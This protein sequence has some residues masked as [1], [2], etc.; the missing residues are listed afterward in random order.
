MR[1]RG[2]VTSIERRKRKVVYTDFEDEIGIGRTLGLAGFDGGPDYERFLRKARVYVFDRMDTLSLRKVYNNFPLTDA[3]IDDL[4]RIIHDAS[5]GTSEDEER[6]A[7]EAGGSGVFIRSLIGLDRNAAKEPF[8]GFL[9]GKRNSS[10]RHGSTSFKGWAAHPCTRSQPTGG[11]GTHSED[12]TLRV[13]CPHRPD[14]GLPS[15][16]R[17]RRERRHLIRHGRKAADQRSPRV[18]RHQPDSAARPASIS[19]SPEAGTLTG[20]T[21]RARMSASPKLMTITDD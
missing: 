20:G 4:R 9:D 8:A 6:A 12:G 5:M 14:V 11:C 15:R 1:L 7:H 3:G 21:S 18:L 13:S 17:A 16:H 19:P 10:T 2:L